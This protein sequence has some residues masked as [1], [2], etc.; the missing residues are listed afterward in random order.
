M[1][2]VRKQWTLILLPQIV[3]IKVGVREVVAVSQCH[4]TLLAELTE[5]GATHQRDGKYL[6]RPNGRGIFGI[7]IHRQKERFERLA[8]VW[9]PLF[10]VVGLP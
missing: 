3:D 6:W 5:T 1:Q 4:P 9:L 7:F 8:L 10:V 2:E